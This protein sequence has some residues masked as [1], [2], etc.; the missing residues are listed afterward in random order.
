[1]PCEDFFVTVVQSLV[2]SVCMH[3]FKMCQL[4]ESPAGE[5]VPL[6]A[7]LEDDKRKQLTTF[8]CDRVVAKH[9]KFEYNINECTK[10]AKP[11]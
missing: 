7:W 9:V 5:V 6:A 1:M 4:D 10:S 11:S 2:V 8:I 3:E